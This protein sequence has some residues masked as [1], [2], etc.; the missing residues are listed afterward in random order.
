M[1][2]SNKTN[3]N[4][5]KSTERILQSKKKTSDSLDYIKETVYQSV[6]VARFGKMQSNENIP[7]ASKLQAR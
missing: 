3:S 1:R 5:L 6:M 2:E 4:Q 7:P